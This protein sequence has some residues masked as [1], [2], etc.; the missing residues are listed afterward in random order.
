MGLWEEFVRWKRF[1]LDTTQ[2]IAAEYGAEPY[3]IWDFADY[4]AYSQ[5][6]LPRLDDPDARMR[7]YWES[8]HYTRA[9]GDRVLDTLLLGKDAGMG[10]KLE[11]DDFDAWIRM[12]EGRRA[13]YVQ[14]AERDLA[15]MREYLFSPGRREEVEALFEDQN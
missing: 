1:L 14:A 13:E 3:P 11:A 5:E 2:E 8:S 4:N 7:W 15:L 10:R 9:L 12:I 6:A